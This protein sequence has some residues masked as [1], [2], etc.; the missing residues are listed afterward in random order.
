[1]RALVADSHTGDVSMR[2]A[3]GRNTAH[4]DELLSLA[5]EAGVA[6]HVVELDVTSQD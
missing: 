4:T 6:F 3:N 2:D 5:K 1:M